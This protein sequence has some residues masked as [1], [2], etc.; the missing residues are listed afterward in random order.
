MNCLRTSLIPLETGHSEPHVHIDY[1]KQSHTASFAIR[2][3]RMLAGNL[4]RKYEKTITEWI[5]NHRDT[6]GDLWTTAQ[7]GEPINELI[8]GIRNA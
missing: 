7:S 1:G 8:V 2:D 4:D 6:L 5:D 3:G